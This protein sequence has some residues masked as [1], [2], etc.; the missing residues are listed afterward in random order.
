MRVPI[1]LLLSTGA[2]AG[3][4]WL[5]YRSE[6]EQVVR[7]N[8]PKYILL[9]G[10][11]DPEITRQV[12]ALSGARVNLW[13]EL[14]TEVSGWSLDEISNSLLGVTA[15]SVVITKFDVQRRLFR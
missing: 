2:I 3:Y 15:E 10:P 1:G 12:A 13:S 11:R 7:L 4:H 8:H 5:I 14:D 9:I 6:Q